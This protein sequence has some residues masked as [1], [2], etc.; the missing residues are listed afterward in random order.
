M[1]QMQAQ[2]GYTERCRMVAHP[3]PSPII[4]EDDVTPL[5]LSLPHI[6]EQR[7]VADFPD[8]EICENGTVK[9]IVADRYGRLTNQPLCCHVVSRYMQVTLFRDHRRHMKKLH[10][11][12][13]GTFVGPAP[14]PRHQGCHNDGNSLNNR[15]SNLR[16]DTPEGNQADRLLHGTHLQGA[17]NPR[18]I[19]T[20]EDVLL[21]RAELS[22]NNHRTQQQ[23]AEHYGVTQGLISQIHRKACWKGQL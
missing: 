23:I 18:A 3:A 9:R 1:Q 21:V 13:L 12:L 11:L 8:Y 5:Q 6:L 14:S 22:S 7:P 19:L 15:L 17:R 20:P 2:I 4:S 10:L 16:W